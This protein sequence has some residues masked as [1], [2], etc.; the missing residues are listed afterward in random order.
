MD[1]VFRVSGRSL[2]GIVVVGL[3]VA[4]CSSG[5][6]G[7]PPATGAPVAPA[8][9]AP[10]DPGASLPPDGTVTS[11]PGGVGQDPGA[12]APNG[13]LV[14]PKPGQLDVHPVP[15]DSFAARVAGSTIVVTATWTSGVEPC[16]T[17]DSIQIDPSAGTYTI[18]ILEGHG[19]EEIACIMIA[20]VK[21]TEF[22]IP[23]GGPG[24]YTLVDGQG[25]AAPLQVTVG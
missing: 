3:L 23:T 22:T 9:T 12:S 5:G 19:P 18:T 20:Q 2:A 6:A 14:I 24:T 1:K 4:A 25:H 8:S 21:R 13:G 10:S 17:L 16:S 7:A 11:P 15:I